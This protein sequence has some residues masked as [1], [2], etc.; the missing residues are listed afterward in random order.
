ML[1]RAVVMR[2]IPVDTGSTKKRKTVIGFVA[3]YPRGYGEHLK[4]YS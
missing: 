4:S 3:V 1:I 2:F